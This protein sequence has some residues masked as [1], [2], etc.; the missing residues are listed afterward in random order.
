MMGAKKIHQVGKSALLLLSILSIVGCPQ[1]TP[2]QVVSQNAT[3]SAANPAADAARPVVNTAAQSETSTGALAYQVCSDIS[4]WQRP[5]AAAQQK[6]LQ[7]DP[8]YQQDLQ[9]Q[10]LKDIAETFWQHEVL[11]FTTY[12]LSARTEPINF[13][14][15]WDVADQIWTDCYTGSAGEQINA[16]ELAEAWLINHRVVDLQWQ[17]DRYVIQVEPTEQGV[18]VV[19]FNRLDQQVELPIVAVTTAGEPVEVFS[20]DW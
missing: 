13:A 15:L 3:D 9:T 8:R 10:P 6:Q 2:S 20:G 14:G 5:T 12:G 7:A 1:I 16:G 19:Q 17:D 18:Q 11:S 4:S